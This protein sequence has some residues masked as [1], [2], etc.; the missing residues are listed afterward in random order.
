MENPLNY[1]AVV[2]GHLSQ[3]G[4][5]QI[6]N[7]SGYVLLLRVTVLYDHIRSLLNVIFSIAFYYDQG[8]SQSIRAFGSFFASLLGSVFTS[9]SMWFV[10]TIFHV[11]FST[12]IDNPMYTMKNSSKGNDILYKGFNI[13]VCSCGPQLSV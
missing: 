6:K 13:H 9:G 7:D 3:A 10:C 2:S 4:A 12:E 8:K 11:V 1:S 5:L